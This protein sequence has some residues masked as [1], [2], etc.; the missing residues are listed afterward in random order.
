M[1]NTKTFTINPLLIKFLL[2]W[3][4][5]IKNNRGASTLYKMLFPSKV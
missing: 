4:K 3:K 2:L 1:G 5:I